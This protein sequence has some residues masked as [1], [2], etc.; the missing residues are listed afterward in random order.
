MTVN[1]IH[2]VFDHFRWHLLNSV[3]VG[4]ERYPGPVLYA[5]R[6]LCWRDLEIHA[7]SPIRPARIR[8]EVSQPPF[9]KIFD[10]PVT[11][12]LGVPLR[13]YTFGSLYVSRRGAPALVPV[14][15][16]F[17][18]PW[19]HCPEVMPK[20]LH[21][22]LA[23]PLL[24]ERPKGFGP[25]PESTNIVYRDDNEYGNLVV[26]RAD[27]MKLPWYHLKAMECFILWAV[28]GTFPGC[29]AEFRR[30]PL[31]YVTDETSERAD[32]ATATTTATA[33][34]ASET[35]ST[36]Y[37]TTSCSSTPG[38]SPVQPH[39]MT[40]LALLNEIDAIAQE[41]QLMAARVLTRQAYEAAFTPELFKEFWPLWKTSWVRQC[42]CDKDVLDR[43]PA[44]W[45][46]S[47]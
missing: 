7:G 40:T 29:L 2:R 47:D 20:P 36:A 45:E 5:H 27:G 30:S 21:N 43:L 42:P 22:Y 41:Y 44:P 15:D 35:K 12:R 11:A 14:P 19:R 38:P 4:Y 1:E 32:T 46:V 26:W 34:R 25:P 10:M 17:K 16:S 8:H 39:Q 9:R 3:L 23:G 24:I 18:S 6:L 37:S 13:F 33:P 28:Q 31:P